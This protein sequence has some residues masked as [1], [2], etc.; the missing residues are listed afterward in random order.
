[1]STV[2]WDNASPLSY[3]RA[4]AR[5][6][7]IAITFAYT[8]IDK[9]DRDFFTKCGTCATPVTIQ[10]AAVAFRVDVVSALQLDVFRD[11]PVPAKPV[12]R[13]NLG[14][15]STPQEP[16]GAPPVYRSLTTCAAPVYR[17]CAPES[18]PVFELPKLEPDT[19][20][21]LTDFSQAPAQNHGLQP[22]PNCTPKCELFAVSGIQVCATV[23]GTGRYF[24][25]HPY[26]EASRAKFIDLMPGMETVQGR[27]DCDRPRLALSSV[28][29]V[30]AA[31]VIKFEKPSPGTTVIKLSTPD[32]AYVWTG[33]V[34]SA[35]WQK[36][37][38]G[39]GTDLLMKRKNQV[40]IKDFQVPDLGPTCVDAHAR[41]TETAA[42]GALV[43]D[44][45]ECP[46]YE[47]TMLAL[48]TSHV[49]TAPAFR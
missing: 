6:H 24:V 22:A 17:S 42:F 7:T 8:A 29:H 47:A 1:M 19:T 43:L 5:R 20:I 18:K 35:S 38:D 25:H 23:L 3:I 41:P 46:A 26:N 32:H 10:G 28:R 45:G 4:L 21:K 13:R 48:A 34:T 14:L 44:V 49:L 27:T 36:L 37:D 30:L 33:G 16:A 12:L 2:S 31:C 39:R 40:V 9:C 15:F 11:E